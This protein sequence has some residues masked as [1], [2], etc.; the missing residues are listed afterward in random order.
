MK[1]YYTYKGTQ[2]PDSSLTV[3]D[4]LIDAKNKKLTLINRDFYF[5]Q[6]SDDIDTSDGSIAL[7]MQGTYNLLNRIDSN[8]ATKQELQDV[9]YVTAKSIL[10]LKDQISKTNSS[11]VLINASNND[12]NTS[13][14]NYTNSSIAY[15]VSTLK[16]Y[17]DKQDSSIFK[18][19]NTSIIDYIDAS[20]I[21][22]I[23]YITD[24]SKNADD[25]FAAVA[26][27]LNDIEKDI[28][29]ISNNY[30]TNSS[31]YENYL[32]KVDFENGKYGNYATV[33]FVNSS[34]ETLRTKDIKNVS[35]NLDTLTK[36]FNKL[37]SGDEQTK[38]NQTIDTFE[39]IEEFLNG[40]SN[41]SQLTDLLVNVKNETISDISNNFV[42]NVSL[43][44]DLSIY[45]K[46]EYVDNK[47]KE[48]S[49]TINTVNSSV[50]DLSTRLKNNYY[51]IENISNNFVSNTSLTENYLTII[52][53]SNTYA[54]I[55][56]LQDVEYVTAKSILDL[57]D[58]LSKVNSSL[59]LMNTSS[60]EANESIINYINSSLNS[61]NSSLVKY[62]NSSLELFNTSIV[63]YVNTSINNL[64]TSLIK[65]ID[66]QDSSLFDFVNASIIDVSK[67]V[68]EMSEVIS[69]SLNEMQIE[70]TTANSSI[71]DISNRIPKYTDQ[72]INNSGFITA[73]DM[74]LNLD[75]YVKTETFDNT[76]DGIN[77]NLTNNYYTKNDVSNH[78]VKDDISTFVTDGSLSDELNKYLPLSGGQMNYGNTSIRFENKDTSKVSMINAVN[79]QVIH[80]DIANSSYYVTRLV[81]NGLQQYLFNDLA[82]TS[83]NRGIFNQLRDGANK[84]LST[85]YVIYDDNNNEDKRIIFSLSEDESKT[86]ILWKGK[87]VNDLITANGGVKTIGTDIVPL[88]NGKIPSEYL[89][90]DIYTTKDDISTF[91]TTTYVNTQIDNN[92]SV[93]NTSINNII[94]V[95]LFNIDSS[96]TDISARLNTLKTNFD[97][98]IGNETDLDGTINTFKEIE[99]FLKDISDSSS[100]T[101]VL[102][103]TK[104]IILTD[105]S[106]NYAKIND[107]SNHVT[108]EELEDVEYVT[109]KSILDL[110][111]QISKVNSSI[112][113]VITDSSSKYLTT[114]DVSNLV[115]DT[116]LTKYYTKTESDSKYLVSND[117]SNLVE[118]T[119]LDNYYT[120]KETD[121]KFVTLTVF[122]DS[123]NE[124]QTQDSSLFNRVIDLST[125]VIENEE[126]VAQ[127]LNILK[128]NVDTINS[129]INDISSRI[130]DVKNSIPSLD[131]YITKDDLTNTLKD[132]YTIENISTNFVSN[133]SLTENYPT[134]T[135][136]ND[137]YVTKTELENNEFVTAKAILELKDTISSITSNITDISSNVTDISS[138]IS[139]TEEVIA[140]TLNMLN[141]SIIQLFELIN[142]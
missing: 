141:A 54:T 30:A 42:S 126:T 115:K 88:T 123:I 21:S 47:D 16:E 72:L 59:V 17:I 105:V 44:N 106:N 84:A 20:D 28:I 12:N 14:L 61:Y 57:K 56:N 101:D 94:N 31:V 125:K 38:L 118:K 138:N 45:A 95:S 50:S 79:V 66:K 40:I 131:D 139:L 86:G 135:S 1:I 109:A 68:D 4:I 127:A 71:K 63:N 140:T 55:E 46:T 67:N 91:T 41:A 90:L 76:I 23:K 53:A 93:L 7:S 133:T 6:L 74:G 129:S 108:K 77:T 75:G 24:V 35:D 15:N 70:I 119:T 113:Q 43:K 27:S 128:L 52:D 142:K 65:Y 29:N 110:K 83:R 48:L 130:K 73:S 80:N 11:L 81:A 117:I 112:N 132:Y 18:Y 78:V 122:D 3:E 49:D 87:T 34:I 36:T 2:V 25:A 98:L 22:I 13:I 99:S 58:Q 33:D 37:V 32:R 62:I 116:D 104:D 89:S 39:E 124:L 96:I 26:V 102:M 82:K 137:N 51:T 69:K 120:K 8:Y 103:N 60:N 134:N 136:L 107:V 19:I 10:D 85:A 100:L 114:N 92:V 111:D 9:E 64:N 97:I 121:D 5:Q